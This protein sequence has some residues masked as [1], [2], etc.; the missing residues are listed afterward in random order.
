MLI[1]YFEEVFYHKS[2]ITYLIMIL[3]I[4]SIDLD[5]FSYIKIILNC[6]FINYF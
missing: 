5:N 4:I 3:G 1:F 6:E 2:S